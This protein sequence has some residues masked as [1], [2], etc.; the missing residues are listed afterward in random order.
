[1]DVLPTTGVGC[2][3]TIGVLSIFVFGAVMTVSAVLRRVLGGRRSERDA[4]ADLLSARPDDLVLRYNIGEAHSPSD[5]IG[6]VALQVGVDGAVRLDVWKV[7]SNA[8]RRDR[9]TAQVDPEEVQQLLDMIAET[10]FP[11]IPLDA[12]SP[13][14][15]CVLGVASG[16]CVEQVVLNLQTHGAR[17][18]WRG[19]LARLDGIVA[20][21]R[22]DAEA[23]GRLGD[24]EVRQIARA[25]APA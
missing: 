24:V 17:E 18:P 16:D 12:P 8:E 13:G 1:M 19:L 6:E 11:D 5:P 9:W 22:G 25:E 2:V 7:F 3:G 23:A 21:T 14:G 15:V 4:Q 20:Q 10:P